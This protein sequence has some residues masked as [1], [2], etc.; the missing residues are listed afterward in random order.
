MDS[1]FHPSI[2]RFAEFMFI[3]GFVVA[4]FIDHLPWSFRVA[5]IALEKFPLSTLRSTQILMVNRF[6]AAFCF[7]AAGFLVDA[8]LSVE[9][10]IYYFS[11]AFGILGVI[12]L[13]YYLC[14]QTVY[15][16]VAR[17]FLG[18]QAH[19]AEVT[20]V[21]FSIRHIVINYPF[22]FN[23]LGVSAPIISAA[24]MPDYRGFLLQLGFIF[25][26][27]A[28]VLVVFVLEPVFVKHISNNDV[29][30]ADAFHQKFI[31]SK[32]MLLIIFSFFGATFLVYLKIYG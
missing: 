28:S 17:I 13:L 9:G 14:W 18:T 5:G 29:G 3:F 11:L 24:A 1:T 31:L 21:P 25:N 20:R 22:I 27:I 4:F 6:G 8:G 32:A 2:I 12:T 10:F 26:S 30:A 23:I 19:R 16:L 7:T 15:T